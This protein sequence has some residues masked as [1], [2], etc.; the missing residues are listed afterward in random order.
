MNGIE[1]LADLV[2]YLAQSVRNEIAELTEEQLK[3]QPDAEG[4]SIAITV[5]H[6]SRWLDLLTVRAFENRSTEEEQWFT[7]GWAEKTGYDPR[8][9]G[10]KGLGAITGYTQE[11]VS[12]IPLLS[13]GE[14]LAYLDQVCAALGGYLHSLSDEALTEPAAGLGG[15]RTRYNWLRSILMG[16]FGHVG[17]VE[18]FKA[19]QQRVKERQ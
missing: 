3:W 13:A 18:A 5:W 6:F 14:L 11:E 19:M 4:N 2:T 17:E 1:V 10:Y 8:G 15:R 7:R 12:A 9:L 16:S